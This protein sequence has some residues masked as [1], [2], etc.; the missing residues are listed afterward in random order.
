MNTDTGKREPRSQSKTTTFTLG[1]QPD[2]IPVEQ[3]TRTWPI[4]GQ[5]YFLK[6]HA[7]TGF[8]RMEYKKLA[9]LS[10]PGMQYTVNFK[11]SDNSLLSVP[12]TYDGVNLLTFAIPAG[13]KNKQKYTL[14]ISRQAKSASS[15]SNKP[16]SSSKYVTLDQSPKLQLYRTSLN[17][18]TVQSMAAVNQ[19]NQSKKLFSLS[20]ATSQYNTFAEKINALNLQATDY[21][22]DQTIQLKPST[23]SYERFDKAELF[24]DLKVYDKFT[25]KKPLMAFE[26]PIIG[27]PYQ[28][29]PYEK[30]IRTQIYNKMRRLTEDGTGSYG[31]HYVSPDFKTQT[32]TQYTSSRVYD[33]EQYIGNIVAI[34]GQPRRVLFYNGPD[35]N[36]YNPASSSIKF[37]FVRDKLAGQDLGALIG[38]FEALVGLNYNDVLLAKKYSA[39]KNLSDQAYLSKYIHDPNAETV[40][41]YNKYIYNDWSKTTYENKDYKQLDKALYNVDGLAYDGNMITAASPS[42]KL[43]ILDFTGKFYRKEQYWKFTEDN[44]Y[45]STSYF[46]YDSRP[47]R[48]KASPFTA[49]FTYGANYD[50]LV[51]TTSL[52][53]V[54]TIG[55]INDS[56]TPIVLPVVPGSFYL[57][58]F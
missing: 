1:K 42:M 15:A 32:L 8:L 11:G 31:D 27:T 28:D 44:Y 57:P 49:V 51:P 4:E 33:R 19:A 40:L 55:S 25:V 20:F 14:E 13:L 53:K 29:S 18:S 43:G 56:S 9:C 12:M 10:E 35:K 54:F 17:L 21:L 26:T 48:T 39:D 23:G 47:Q 52:N 16:L 50:E 58:G 30:E 3:V 6:K 7:P 46:D 24:D 2:Y 5:R 37:D 22:G 36:V 34:D 45:N 41:V 38:I